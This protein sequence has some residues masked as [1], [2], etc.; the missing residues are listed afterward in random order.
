MKTSLLSRLTVSGLFFCLLS[1]HA[2][3][4]QSTAGSK[5]K[6][7]TVSSRVNKILKEFTVDD[8]LSYIGG[9]GF[10]DFKSIP[11]NDFSPLNPQLYQTDGPLG[12]RRNEPSIR[13]PSG[14][15]LAATWNPDRAHDQG[16]GMG[17]DTRARGYFSILGPGM[18]FYRVPMGGRNFEYM[19]GED[20]F[21]G[22]QLIPAEIQGIQAQ[23][24]WACAKHYVCNDEEENRTNV[25]IVV[26]ERTLREIYLPPFE[27]AVKVGHVATV[28]GSY[29]AVDSAGT[30]AFACENPFLLTTIL[31]TQW[32]FTGILMSDYNAIHDGLSAALAGCDIDLPSGSFMNQ[33]NLSPWIPNPLTVADLD[34]KVKRILTG[35]ISYGFLDRQQLDTSIPLDDPFSEQATLDVA[36]EGLI[37]LQ[38]KGNLLPLNKNTV[39]KIAVI[40]NL[41]EYAPP[42]GFGSSYVTPIEYVSELDGIKSKVGPNTEVD[43][44]SVCSLDPANTIWEY[45]NNGEITQGL[46]ASYYTSN[47]LSGTPA[48]TRVDNEVNFDWDI[49]PIP[50]S[51]NQGGFSAKW[52]GQIVVPTSGD[53]V[54]KVRGDG[55]LRF[56]LNG[57]AIFDNFNTPTTPPVGYGPTP[58]YS[59]KATLTAGKVYTVEI[60]YRRVGGFFDTFEEGGLTGIQVSYASLKP[61]STIAG[62]NAVIIAAGISSEYEGE[63]EDRSF[64]LPEFQ[65][66]LIKNVSAANP[67][68][69]VVFHGGG[70][71]DSEQW[72]NQV[73]GLVEA[74]YPGQLG[75]QALAEILFGDV[76][77]S[78]K[79]PITMEVKAS[80]NPA[81]ATFPNPVNQHPD[82][83]MYSEGV[84]IG[85][86]GYEKSGITPLF[87]FGFGLSYTTFSFSNLS[88][89]GS[90]DGTQP[91]SVSFM[92]T[93]TGNV[94]GAEV[95]Q[96][97]V[98][99]QNPPVQRP[100]RELKGFQKVFLQPGQSQKVTLQL[101]QRSFAYWNVNIEKWDAPKDTYNVWVGSSSQLSDLTQKGQ[102]T[103]TQDVTANP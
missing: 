30:D 26:D 20:P 101:D 23:G 85:Y 78:G 56:I 46:Q 43:F 82:D 2:Q 28:M 41:A 102:V 81:Y 69:V 33:K 38:N 19:T 58:A 35:A 55:G 62:Y 49:D 39:T 7:A 6:P 66:E 50:V 88:I 72:I 92:V 86:R 83:I 48:V 42:T 100:S 47:D 4:S 70:N 11:V 9:T 96:L 51:T 12:V 76:N 34:L 53:Y 90:F 98:G 29:N 1:A 61:P 27:A 75:G 94:A 22:S 18:D 13:F 95:A 60:D 44:I 3:Q 67:R 71:F 97:Y 77:P 103:V 5:L 8:A 32:G 21:L 24:V 45:S 64:T 65:D 91:V 74:F 16:V 14:L 52:V 57:T 63:G 89:S 40:G 59:A 36:R 31:R 73:D 80:D 87:P 79:L 84:F 37:L 68:T 15:T 99:E 25:H 93:N 10:F 54:F 17:R